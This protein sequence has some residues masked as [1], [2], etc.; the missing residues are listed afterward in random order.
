MGTNLTIYDVDPS[1]LLLPATLKLFR[2]VI[3]DFRSAFY[4]TE[5][6]RK[7]MEKEYEKVVAARISKNDAGSY[8]CPNITSG[9]KMVDIS[10]TEFPSLSPMCEQ[11]NESHKARTTTSFRDR[12]RLGIR[13]DDE[14]LFPVLTNKSAEASS[15]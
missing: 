10:G 3:E 8:S 13:I 15:W 6:R 5:K 4:S 14:K 7:K 2:S 11:A 9:S 12:A 1:P